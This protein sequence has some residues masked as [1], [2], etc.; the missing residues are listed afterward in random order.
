[1]FQNKIITEIF[2]LNDKFEQKLV[3]LALKI[4]ELSIESIAIVSEGLY[5]LTF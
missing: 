1:M 3:K 2:I 4:R 5:S